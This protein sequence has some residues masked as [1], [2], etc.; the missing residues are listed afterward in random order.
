L[1]PLA[2][3]ES[4][5]HHIGIIVG[6]E[7]GFDVR[8][9]LGIGHA[10]CIGS[11]LGGLE[12][13]RH[14]QRDIL[15]VIAHHIILERWTTLVADAAES[16]LR[17]RP[18]DPSD[19]VAMKNRLYAGHFLGSTR[20]DPDDAPIGDRRLDRHGIEHSRKVEIGGVPCRPGHFERAI[21]AR[22]FAADGC[23]R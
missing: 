14:G 17:N 6:L 3:G 9:F 15:T 19:V 1:Q 20:V 2:R 13:V 5:H 18:V 23:V 7:I 22:R 8:L 16:L 4:R 11:G 21:H 10:H 12:C